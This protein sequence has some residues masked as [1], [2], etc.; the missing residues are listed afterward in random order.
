M[1]SRSRQ[2][3][4]LSHDLDFARVAARIVGVPVR[5]FKM[6]PMADHSVLDA[7]DLPPLPGR[8]YEQDYFKLSAYVRDPAHYATQL[9]EV[10]RCVRPAL[11][12]YL[13][14]KFPEAWA[15]ND[16]LGPMIGK[17]RSAQP[18]DNLSLAAHLV[19]DLTELNEYCKRFS[20]SE[21][22]GSD[23]ADIDAREL[24]NYVNQTLKAISR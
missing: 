10:A 24:M 2:C 4:V 3:F 16:W 8:A 22:D 1:A 5:T 11:E 17:I 6:D 9:K 20:H 19:Q 14:T 15:E 7:G 13:R 18:G 21:V 23:A 12:G